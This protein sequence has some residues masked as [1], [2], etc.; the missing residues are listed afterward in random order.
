VKSNF[1]FSEA[2]FNEITKVFNKREISFF[3]IK[4]HLSLLV[5]IE[6]QI[7]DMCINLYCAFTGALQNK[8]NCKYCTEP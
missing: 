4:K 5:G 3:K 1:N 8:R 2:A 7:Y 6:L